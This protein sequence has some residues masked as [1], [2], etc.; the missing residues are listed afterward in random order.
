MKVFFTSDSAEKNK[1][2]MSSM[3]SIPT[4]SPRIISELDLFYP[5]RV[6]LQNK[7]NDL[8]NSYLLF[9]VFKY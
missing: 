4:Y 7:E 3:I 5:S 8:I 6:H 2:D 9:K 1:N